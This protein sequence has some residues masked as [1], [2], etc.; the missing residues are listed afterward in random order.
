PLLLTPSNLTKLAPGLERPGI[1][2]GV[3]LIDGELHIWGTTRSVPDLCFVLD[4]SEPALLVIKHRSLSGNGKFTNVVVLQ[5]DKVK[6]VNEASAETSDAPPILKWL[7]DARGEWARND[8]VNVYIQLALSMRRHGHGGILLIAP[9]ET[10]A[11]QE[12]VIQPMAYS[13]TPLEQGLSV[14]VRTNG[15]NISHNIWQSAL[16]REVDHI[17]G[18][19]AIDGATVVNDQHELLTFGAKIGRKSGGTRVERISVIEPIVGGEAR[20]I[21][22]AMSGGTRHLSAAQFIHD[23]RNALALVASQDGRFT[24]FTW[25]ESQNMVLAYRIEALLL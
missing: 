1:H 19:T 20:I 11:W 10:D 7:L 25:S 24:V 17:A 21:H 5:G 2:V 9:S 15:D 18:L 22:P 3:W 12:S 4:V 14:L 8:A 23:Q 6:I 13:I 16:K